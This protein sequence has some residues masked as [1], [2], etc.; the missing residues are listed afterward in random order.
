MEACIPPSFAAPARSRGDRITR[1]EATHACAPQGAAVPGATV[2][3]PE[4]GIRLRNY[5]TALILS[6]SLTEAEL[7]QEVGKVVDLIGKGGGVH[8]GTQRWGRRMLTFPIKKQTEG[9]YFFVHWQGNREISDSI[10]WNLKIDEKV[11]RHLTLRLEEG[12]E[13]VDLAGGADEEPPQAGR[14]AGFTDGFDGDE[15][16]EQDSEE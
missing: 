5:E 12:E 14:G 16:S 8:S 10:D 1:P 9:V 4:G 13:A 15:E 3:L 7:E 6:A 11:L 2:T